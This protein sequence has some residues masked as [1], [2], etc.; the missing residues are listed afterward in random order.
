M[1]NKIIAIGLILFIA[2]SCKKYLE[3]VPQNAVTEDNFFRSAS[4]FEQAVSGIYAPLRPIYESHWILAEL[5]S[6]NTFFAYS[7]AQRGPEPIE[8]FATF[9]IVSNNTHLLDNWTNN[10][11]IVSRANMVLSKIDGVDFDQTEKNNLKGQAFFLRALAYYDLVRNFGGVPLPTRPAATYGGAFIDRSSTED[12]YSQIISDADS[13]VLLLPAKSAQSVGRPAAG[14]AATLLGSV[15]ITLARWSD[16]ESVLRTVLP[17]GYSLLSNYADVFSPTNKYNDEMIFEV[18]YVTGT[19]QPLYS[20]FPYTF[21]PQVADP[22]VFTGIVP[23]PANGSGSFNVPTP[24]LLGD[25]EDTIHDTRYAAS[26]AFYSGASTLPGITYNH[27]PYIN[28]YQHP[29]SIAAQTAQDWPVFRYAEVLLMLAESLNEQNKATDALPFLNQ[30]R[31]RAGLNPSTITNQADLRQVILHERRIELAFEDK[32][33]YDL[34]RTGMA[35]SVMNNFGAEVKADPQAYYYPAGTTPVASSF[36]LTDNN[37]VFPIPGTEIII[38]P[39]LT[40][41]PGY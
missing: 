25:Y 34:V 10:Y 5:P 7:T 2:G 28:K 14:A 8:N 32:R 6:D 20:V 3:K 36:M 13:A 37:M 15:Y 21:L 26:I 39:H 41:N 30:V 23:E 11:L 19:S 24:D 16:A 18:G 1:K 35:V 33:W 27:F 22:S 31:Q 12:V 9:N 38:N 17:M 40:Q 4:D 29:H